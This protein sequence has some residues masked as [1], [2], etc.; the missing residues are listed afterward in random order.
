M[1]EDVNAETQKTVIKELNPQDSK[2]NPMPRD[3]WLLIGKDIE[4]FVGLAGVE[5][6]GS[7]RGS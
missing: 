6:S 5:Y 7:K 3:R 1:G 2:D 4:P